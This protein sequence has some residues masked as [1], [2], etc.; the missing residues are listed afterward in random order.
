MTVSRAAC[1]RAP[2]S[3][4]Q[5]ANFGPWRWRCLRAVPVQR[6]SSSASRRS[7]SLAGF[8][9]FSHVLDGPLRLGA[10]VRF[11]GAIALWATIQ[12]TADTARFSRVV[13]AQRRRQIARLCA[14]E[15]WPDVLCGHQSVCQPPSG[16]FVFRGTMS[17]PAWRFLQSML[18]KLLII[19]L[20]ATVFFIRVATGAELQSSL[21]SSEKRA[22]EAR[23][24]WATINVHNSVNAQ[25]SGSPTHHSRAGSH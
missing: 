2:K 14:S 11:D 9:D 10:S 5:Q 21:P 8:F 3:L 13:L 24:V 23:L 6:H 15:R 22:T 20:T 17:C 7:A 4:F 19:V 18:N 1:Y 25:N 12:V 16:P